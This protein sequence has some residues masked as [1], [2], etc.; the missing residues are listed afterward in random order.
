MKVTN[1][2]L[3]LST[4]CNANCPL[5]VHDKSGDSH[6]L[7][8]LSLEN[9]KR[10]LQNSITDHVNFIQLCGTHGD[11]IMHKNFI[12][13]IKLIK[14]LKPYAEI[15]I[16]TNGSLRPQKFWKD[17]AIILNGKD[18]IIFG[19][20]GLADTH[21]IYRKNTNFDT[22]IKNARCFIN[23]NGSAWWQFIPFEH[24]QHQIVDA[25]NLSQK[26]NFAK[27]F[28]KHERYCYGDE[29]KAPTIDVSKQKEL[30]VTR[31]IAVGLNDT[32]VSS[33]QFSNNC[34]HLKHKSIYIKADGTVT[35]CCFMS[36]FGKTS[37]TY[38]HLSQQEIDS[39]I[40]RLIQSWQTF[41]TAFAECKSHC[42]ST[43]NL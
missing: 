15:E 3:E 39:N 14:N 2:H 22:V 17:L 41:D 26:Y 7:M 24:N 30:M 36:K 27:F 11:P 18:H 38:K 29:V 9:I 40:D 6:P 13:V 34:I 37:I 42:Y 33:K 16:S 12:A 25:Y 4:Y 10:L 8:H 1:L 35:P 28:V 5:C 20:D 31:D 19:L 23:N 21:H 43:Q 32:F